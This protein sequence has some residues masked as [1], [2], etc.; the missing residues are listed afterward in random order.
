MRCKNGQT[1]RIY[2]NK[3]NRKS[4]FGVPLFGFIGQL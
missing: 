2:D 1:S 4:R 3:K